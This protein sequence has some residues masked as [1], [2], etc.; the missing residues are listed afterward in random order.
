MFLSIAPHVWGASLVSRIDPWVIGSI[1][2]HIKTIE[3]LNKHTQEDSLVICAPNIGWKLKCRNADLMM[4]TAFAG[5]STFV[6][7]KGLKPERFRWNSNIEDAEYLVI[8][9]IDRIWTIGQ[10]N[11]DKV[12]N[13]YVIQR[14]QV[15]Y[16]SGTCVILKQGP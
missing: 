1:Q 13:N 4:S 15:V 9:D 2:D 14:W 11:V 6:Y 12:L 3:W 8:T 10:E 7:P 5:Y 16:Q